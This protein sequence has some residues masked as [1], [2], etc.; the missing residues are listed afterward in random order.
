MLKKIFYIIKPLIPRK[1][2]LQLR[3]KLIF[4]KLPSY[5]DI[6]PILKG[7]EKKPDYFVGWPEGKQ[8]T[9][10]LTHDVEHKR[11]YDRLI[12]LMEIEKRLGF[13]SSFNFVPERD[14]KVEKEILQTLRENGFDYGVHGLYHDGKLFSSESEFL[15][16]A[17]KINSYLKDWNTK[18]FRAPAMHHN[19]DWLG[20]LNIDYDMSTFDTDPFEPQPD[21]V[22]TIFPFWVE[23][24]RNI[25]GGYIELP[26]T[27][28]QDFTPFILMNELTPKIWI[29]KLDWIAEH[30]GMALV[31]V[32]P[33]Y[34]DFENSGNNFE[35]FKLKIYT[36]FLE[37]VKTKYEG[38]Y[39]NALPSEVASFWKRQLNKSD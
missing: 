22:G 17:T 2:Q 33:D 14:Y 37:Y 1:L 15:R 4:S 19:L 38:K 25:N 9:L 5:K 28:P 35:E 23:N 16:R 10:V 6:W 27:L 24:K 31:N 8:F 30:N 12:K 29:D 13:V 7:S 32:H 3:R 11:G 36:D 21:G 34:I 18:G 26:Y 39:W 20:A